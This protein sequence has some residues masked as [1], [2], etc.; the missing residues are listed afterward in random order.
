MDNDEL[1]K[2]L[3]ITQESVSYLQQK[4]LELTGQVLTLAKSYNEFLM[5]IKS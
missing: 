5:Q 2:Q 3:K 1:E 4:F